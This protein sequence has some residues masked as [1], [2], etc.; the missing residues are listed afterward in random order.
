MIVLEMASVAP[1]EMERTFLLV[2]GQLLHEEESLD[3]TR[4]FCS[5][6][7]QLGANKNIEY[8]A[9]SNKSFK[10]ILNATIALT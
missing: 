2:A 5:R 6:S 4:R 9:G 8:I 10:T 3:I 7:Q 1:M